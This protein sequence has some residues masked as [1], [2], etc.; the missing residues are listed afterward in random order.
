MELDLELNVGSDG[1]QTQD[2]VEVIDEI[3]GVDS[4]DLATSQLGDLT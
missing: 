1:W 4:L 3:F 2:I